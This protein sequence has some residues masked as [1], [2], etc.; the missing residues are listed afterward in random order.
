MVNHMANH[1]RVISST[2]Y[3]EHYRR[4]GPIH[5]LPIRHYP[6]ICTWAYFNLHPEMP[7]SPEVEGRGSYCIVLR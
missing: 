7:T 6:Q 1:I 2:W 4:R 3:D 5:S